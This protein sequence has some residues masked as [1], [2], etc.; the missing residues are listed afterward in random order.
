[1]SEDLVSMSDNPR[2]KTTHQKH[3]LNLESLMESIGLQQTSTNSRE[4]S[5][6][7]DEFMMNT[8]TN[9]TSSTSRP[10]SIPSVS[11]NHTATSTTNSNTETSKHDSK[12]LNRISSNQNGLQDN[13][14]TVPEDKSSRFF[15]LA[16]EEA[17]NE[18][19]DDAICLFD[20]AIKTN[21]TVSHYFWYRAL[22]H[23]KLENFEMALID[24]D[25]AI[26]LQPH[27]AA[28]YFRRAAALTG[29]ARQKERSDSHG[30]AK[31][32]WEAE[33]A[34]KKCVRYFSEDV[35]C[36]MTQLQTLLG[37]ALTEMKQAAEGSSVDYQNLKEPTLITERSNAKIDTPLGKTI[38]TNTVSTSTIDK[39]K[40]N[41]VKQ[42]PP[43]LGGPVASGSKTY[44][45]GPCNSDTA[46]LSNLIDKK[47][48]SKTH[49]N[50]PVMVQP[51]L[52]PA[53][54]DNVPINANLKDLQSGISNVTIAPSTEGPNLI[55]NTIF[56]AFSGASSIWGQGNTDIK[57]SNTVLHDSWPKPPIMSDSIQQTQPA[58]TTPNT[59]SSGS[60]V[61]HPSTLD[62]LDEG[63]DEEIRRINDSAHGNSLAPIKQST[64]YGS[65]LWGASNN[66]S[67]LSNNN[68][69]H[70]N[71]LNNRPGGVQSNSTVDHLSRTESLSSMSSYT[72][73]T[74]DVLAGPPG[75]SLG[76]AQASVASGSIQPPKPVGSEINA[77]PS[78]AKIAKQSSMSIPSSN[79]A[80]DAFDELEDV[81]YGGSPHNG[82]DA[83]RS[84]ITPP[85]IDLETKAQKEK[86]L[87]RPTNIMGYHG[88]W[89]GNISGKCKKPILE[90]HL[91]QY[92]PVTSIHLLSDRVSSNGTIS[93][94]VN[95][96]SPNAPVEV[97]HSLR[98]KFVKNICLDKKTPL[99]FRF[100]PTD[101]QKKMFNTKEDVKVKTAS[102]GEC[103]YWRNYTKGCVRESDCEYYHYP[104]NKAIDNPPW[105]IQGMITDD[106]P[107][108]NKSPNK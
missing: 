58:A 57:S 47:S 94:F 15:D 39:S 76:P 92:G 46:I 60:T 28:Y 48:N 1:M 42:P 45:N 84:G 70:I 102:T 63:D 16:L 21:S 107:S 81:S 49:A 14:L 75:F 53:S 68:I 88:L 108:T 38:N 51:S 5:N 17:K 98:G 87:K 105:L 99:Q 11:L 18:K 41:G 55:T 93:A 91:M 20:L 101:H 29:L 85:A 89:I 62:F 40:S 34:F 83:F 77:Q 19:Y 27:E 79:N 32:L 23:L 67:I 10:P 43:G 71:D 50:P 54:K 95:F 12:S 74:S 9:S 31:L 30:I 56:P 33:L 26:R 66:K 24:A 90:Q 78:W 22:S 86:S 35:T 96:K 97:I 37:T 104:V 72:G 7:I 82:K 64:D 13:G 2:F 69:H 100:T 44:K 73:G 106:N 4:V 52:W 80:F 103:F 65:P 8:T 59:S 25:E 6:I 3:H 61:Q 36:N